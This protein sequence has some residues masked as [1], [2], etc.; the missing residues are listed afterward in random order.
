MTRRRA[1]EMLDPR[2]PGP[3]A[4]AFRW[5][6]HA[7]V[8]VGILAM[9]VDT[10]PRIRSEW[11]GVLEAIFNVTLAFFIVEYVLRL[12]VA[13]EAPWA[14]ADTPWKDR[15]HWAVSFHGI[16]ELLAILPIALGTVFAADPSLVRL[17][18]IFW[19][20]RGCPV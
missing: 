19:L 16:V 20:L 14:H 6:H 4:H 1:Y 8:L 7:A 17:L 10:V 5:V 13:P 15:L 18:S 9:V 3:A 11:N 12:H 2:T